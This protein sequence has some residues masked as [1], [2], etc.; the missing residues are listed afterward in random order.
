MTL[1]DILNNLNCYT[2]TKQFLI[3][4]HVHNYNIQPVTVT[5]RIALIMIT[6]HFPFDKQ[7]L[8]KTSIEKDNYRTK[9][10]LELDENYLEIQHQN[11]N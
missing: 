3:K 9:I 8:Y 7:H 1:T 5:K 4:G 6:K 2:P 11:K 10:L